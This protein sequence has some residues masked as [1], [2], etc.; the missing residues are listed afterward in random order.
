MKDEQSGNYGDVLRHIVP[1]IHNALAIILGN[2]QLLLFG[3]MVNPEEREKLNA[4]EQGSFRIQ[5]LIE[6]L[7]RERN[8]PSSS[9]H[10]QEHGV[11]RCHHIRAAVP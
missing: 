2:A 8:L 11:T 5:T 6:E 1:E 9:Q 7:M 4:I 10:S 3:T